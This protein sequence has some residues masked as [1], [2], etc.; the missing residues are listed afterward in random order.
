MIK[1]RSFKSVSNAFKLW[2]SNT[3]IARVIETAFNKMLELN[4]RHANERFN[5]SAFILRKTINR[6]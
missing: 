1:N 5:A 2:K 4:Y 6:I 3:T